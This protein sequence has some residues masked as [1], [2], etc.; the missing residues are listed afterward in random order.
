MTLEEV[1]RYVGSG[2]GQHIEFKLRAPLPS[3]LAKEVIAFANSGGGKV[4]IGVDDD[5]SIV[6]VKDSA[7]EEFSLREAMSRYCRPRIQWYSKRVPVTKKRDVIVVSV[8]SSVRKPHFIVSDENRRKGPAYVRIQDMSIEA[9][10][11]SIKLMQA[12]H[13]DEGVHFEFS[14]KELLLMRYLEQYSKVTVNGFAQIADLS[15]EQ[16]G[17]VLVTMTRAGILDQ[18]REPRGDYYMISVQE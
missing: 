16:A 9:T 8:P 10:P 5:G 13:L 2:E 15:R 3:R 17:H 18:Y 11:E 12:E 1:Q 6:G 4:F 7:E 14:E